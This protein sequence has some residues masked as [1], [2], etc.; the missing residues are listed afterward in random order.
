VDLSGTGNTV[1][2]KGL[3]L[4]TTNVAASG[5][6]FDVTV[7]NTVLL[8]NAQGNFSGT[9]TFRFYVGGSATAIDVSYDGST[10]ASASDSNAAVALLN[11]AIAAKGISGVTASIASDGKL[12]FA[13]GSSFSVKVTAGSTLATVNAKV[14]Y[15][16]GMYSVAS[17]T[18]TTGTLSAAGGATVVVTNAQ[19]SAT[20]TFAAGA[21]YAN[22]GAYVTAVNQAL[23]DAGLTG[24]TATL[25]ASNNGYT[26]QSS[27]TFTVNKTADGFTNNV[28]FGAANTPG[29]I[30]L[31][32]GPGT[33]IAVTTG[34]AAAYT[35]VQSITAAI[36]ALGLI[37]GRVG[38]GENML[39]YAVNLAQSQIT[40]FSSAEAQIRD[41]DVA[42]EAANL[43][44]AQVLQQASMAAMAQANS[45]PQ[46]VLALLRG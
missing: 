8:N 39:K 2:A 13:S 41:A 23:S 9:N 46:A 5:T 32:N 11:S 26:L 40:N 17:G 21:T 38:A 7:P 27:S 30:A 3:G 31:T 42:S 25:N 1:D 43:T 4:S 28:V 24:I 34:S 45:A 36:K 37:Q 18:V 16:A 19:G 6:E 10:L 15:N 35:A 29:A 44:K 22:A 14:D 20:L 12:Q 33:N